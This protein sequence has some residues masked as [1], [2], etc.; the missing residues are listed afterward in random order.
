MPPWATGRAST[1]LLRPDTRPQRRGTPARR[2][3]ARTSAR[4]GGRLASLAAVAALGL[5]VAA[6]GGGATA[7]TT[8]TTTPPQ[9]APAGANKIGTYSIPVI[10]TKALAALSRQP[11]VAVH[12]TLG[13]DGAQ[14]AADDLVAVGNPTTGAAAGHLTV[15]GNTKVFSLNGSLS[16]V[17]IGKSLWVNGD[18][19]FWSSLVHSS[20]A[21]SYSGVD[22]DTF[23][24]K[25]VGH[26][27]RFDTPSAEALEYHLLSL[28]S[29]KSIVASVVP[30]KATGY[31]KEL[32]P[33]I[34]GAP[35]VA[36][37]SEKGGSVAISTVGEPLP[38]QISGSSGSNGTSQSVLLH[39]TYPR[40]PAITAPAGAV[41]LAAV[42]AASKS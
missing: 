6:C 38:L 22:L 15:S 9:P 10:A 42:V 19:A 8:T 23:Y 16:F 27:I 11:A 36:L 30:L 3:A 29:P 25:V 14:I 39:F 33:T 17:R 32:G 20:A 37:R 24:G 41:G 31:T 26:W 13:A 34:D 5:G 1:H 28:T 35:T 12:G 18:R 4:L 21:A 2:A 40:P 7:T